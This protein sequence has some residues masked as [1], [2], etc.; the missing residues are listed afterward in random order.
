MAIDSF[1][2][3]PGSGSSSAGSS[4]RSSQASFEI[5]PPQ[6][7]FGGAGLNALNQFRDARLQF[8]RNILQKIK[9]HAEDIGF[10]G[11][12]QVSIIEVEPQNGAAANGDTEENG[13]GPVGMGGAGWPPQRQ[14]ILPQQQQFVPPQM[15]PQIP[16]LHFFPHPRP[17]IE[18]F[19]ARIGNSE[20]SC[21]FF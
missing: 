4:S 13:N 5:E 9:Q 19:K 20:F 15:P 10:D 1:P 7:I 14:L 16:P 21:I 2:M 11:T 8:L 18:D 17:L 3:A 6:P 12:M